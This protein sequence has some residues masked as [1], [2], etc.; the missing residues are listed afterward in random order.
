MG[1]VRADVDG[2]RAGADPS[3]TVDRRAAH[4]S[5][6]APPS[7]TDTRR[8]PLAEIHR[9]VRGSAPGARAVPRTPT[10]PSHARPLS[11]AGRWAVLVSSLTRTT[12]QITLDETSSGAARH[13]DETARGVRAVSREERD[14]LAA[15]ETALRA[16]D[17]E[18]A[19]MLSTFTRPRL[20]RELRTVLAAVLTLVPLILVLHSRT[21]AILIGALIGTV[22]VLCSKHAF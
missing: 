1:G 4:P 14:A 13:D 3:P 5:L 20:S 15:I 19:R 21:A 12:A 18:L 9:R 8:C 17:P 22:P 2:P 10:S 7:L 16:D 6:A 11:L